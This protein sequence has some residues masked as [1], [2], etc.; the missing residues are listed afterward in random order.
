M[1]GGS[2]LAL[3]MR[4]LAPRRARE[5][6]DAEDPAA[7]GRAFGALLGECGRCHAAERGDLDVRD[8]D[9]ARW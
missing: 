9:A 2:P 3:E 8:A 5:L 6:A 1:T 4:G 7:A